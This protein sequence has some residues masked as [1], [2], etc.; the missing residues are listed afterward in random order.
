MHDPT[1]SYSPHWFETFLATVPAEQTAAE[2]AFLTRVLPRPRFDAVLDLCCGAGR[3][4]IPLARLGYR[5]TGLDRSPHALRAARA[6]APAGRAAAVGSLTL[7]EDDVRHVDRLPGDY[8]AALI[9]WASFGY[10]DDAT[11]ER[12]LAGAASRLRRGGRLVV[13][14]YHRAFFAGRDGTR[15]HE[16]G[17]ARIVET[18]RLVGDR[19][20]V[21]L[22]YGPERPADA[23]AWRL[24]TPEELSALGAAHGLRTVLA[25]TRFDESL[26]PTAEEPRMQLVFEK[27]DQ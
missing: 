13:D 9:M 17:D 21:L 4:A 16:R 2:V 5:V 6:A 22:E 18:K 24:Y 20:T 10:F 15:V 8:D 23:M 25:C 27:D 3:H 12:V 1:N 14:L 11:N 19:L 7:I 26:A